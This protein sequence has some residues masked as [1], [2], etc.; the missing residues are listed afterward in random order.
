MEALQD[1]P[2]PI[3]AV[4]PGAETGVELADQLSS[5]LGL[6][7]NGTQKSIARRNKYYMGETVRETGKVDTSPRQVYL[8][9]CLLT[10]LYFVFILYRCSCC[11]TRN[12]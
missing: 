1:L 12:L 7:S 2:F 8:V 5:R 11:E 6:R 9:K 10:L 4:I 3:L